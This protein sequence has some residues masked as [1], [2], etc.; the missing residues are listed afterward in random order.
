MKSIFVLLILITT[1]SLGDP[2]LLE[3]DSQNPSTGYT[4]PPS[5][6]S[7]LFDQSYTGTMDNAGQAEDLYLRAEDFYLTEIGIIESVEWW[8][9]FVGSQS[10]TFHLRIYD[11][12]DSSPGT[13]LWEVPSASVTN[14]DTGDELSGNKIYHSE[15]T[16]DPSEYFQTEENGIYWFSM[17]HNGVGFYW[18]LLTQDGNMA[19]CY[20]GGEWSSLDWIGFFRI[21]GTFN[22]ALETTT[23][24]GIKAQN[25]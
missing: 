13:L 4:P 11:D 23:W 1:V 12:N 25:Q 15:V 19:L 21:N 14:T 6:R 7:I 17:H 8:G 22:Q 20:D 3:T 10:N 2:L 9:V 16:L 5:S 18:G 24:A